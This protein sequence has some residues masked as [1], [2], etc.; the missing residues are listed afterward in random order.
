MGWSVP[1]VLLQFEVDA[2]DLDLFQCTQD[3]MGRLICLLWETGVAW[4]P[5]TSAKFP[6]LN[7]LA[8]LQVQ[9]TRVG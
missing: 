6:Y 1:D 3:G 9:S 4:N 8:F 2:L 5:S 7:C